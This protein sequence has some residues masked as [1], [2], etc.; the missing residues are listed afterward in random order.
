MASATSRSMNPHLEQVL[1]DA[2]QELQHLLQQKTELMRRIGTIRQTIIGLANLFG[3]E[4][5]KDEFLGFVASKSSPR[6][7]GFTKACRMALIETRHAMMTAEVCDWIRQ[8]D[9]AMLTRHKDPMV[10][11]STVLNRLVAYGEVQPVNLP[12]GR[13]AWQW[14]SDSQDSEGKQQHSAE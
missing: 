1:R 2:R 10:S 4:A 3:D 13:R 6:R 7:P 5:L 11:V 14:R 12:D 8:K 9:P